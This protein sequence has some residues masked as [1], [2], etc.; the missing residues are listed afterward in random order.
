MFVFVFCQARHCGGVYSETVI[1]HYNIPLA[2]SLTR[3][4]MIFFFFTLPLP[5]GHSVH[6]FRHFVLR[7]GEGMSESQVGNAGP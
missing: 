6:S 1:H 2:H 5:H 7:L 4:F 3:L